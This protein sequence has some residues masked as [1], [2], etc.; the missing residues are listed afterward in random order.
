MLSKESKITM[1]DIIDF[2]KVL[3]GNDLDA[4]LAKLLDV[5]ATVLPAMQD[6]FGDKWDVVDWIPRP[7]NLTTFIIDFSVIENSGLK[8]IAKAYILN[9]RFSKKI[10]GRTALGYIYAIENLDKI[11]KSKSVAKLSGYDFYETEKALAERYSS[12]A[13]TYLR[14]LQAFANWLKVNLF[15]GLEFTT[16]TRERVTYGRGGTDEGRADKLLPDEVVSQIFSIAKRPELNIKDKFFL[17]AFVLN[18]VMQGRVNELATLPVNCIINTSGVIAIKVFTEKG[19]KLGV[20]HFP[21]VIAPAVEEAVSF[22]RSVTEEG[23]NLIRESRGC[24]SF[25]WRA[26]LSDDEA[27]RYFTAK[28]VSDWTSAHKL[29]DRNAVWSKSLGCSIDAIGVLAQHAGSYREACK[30]ICISGSH[31]RRLVK[32]QEAAQKGMYLV[33]DSGILR[34]V[35]LNDNSWKGAVRNNPLAISV[36]RIEK[37]YE[38]NLGSKIDIVADILDGGLRSQLNGSIYPPPK[39]NMSFEKLYIKKIRPVVSA[40]DGTPLLEAEDALFVVPRN[41]LNSNKTKSSQYQLISDGMFK[42]WLY[43]QRGNDSVFHKYN[44]MNP[45]TGSV[46]EFTWHDIRHWLQT[47]LKRGGLTDTQASL[48][49]GRKDHD[50]VKVYDYIPAMVRSEQLAKMRRNIQ[51]GDVV[52][53][54]ADTYYKLK[55]E[56]SQLAEDYLIA[57]TLV[58]NWMPHGGCTLNL[59]L[60]PCVHNLSCFSSSKGGD[61]C[62]HLQVNTHDRKQIIEVNRLHQ[63][64]MTLLR[65]MEEIGG[66]SSPQYE[67]Y[68]R[69]ARNTQKLLDKVE[70][71]STLGVNF[72]RQSEIKSD[73]AS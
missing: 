33:V 47:V 73:N 26:I 53:N 12:K 20:R 4:K 15:P 11:L 6:V 32:Q 72:L 35:D 45:H 37:K 31:L 9:K 16:F 40:R 46:A 29:L 52:G 30:T 55:V 5:Y 42:L 67:H 2:R 7:G 28:F 25:D 36:S 18:T 66:A 70:Y 14:T 27:L 24:P 69:V 59:A 63:D 22:I 23:R 8:L 49:A 13:V 57:S 39:L 34:G 43:Q 3:L 41:F 48:L 62:N 56:N 1:R 44:I 64:S 61:L 71:E 60:T 68:S 54:T 10:F 51:E 17:S 65:T 19:G 58:V 21:Q 50:Q 38:I